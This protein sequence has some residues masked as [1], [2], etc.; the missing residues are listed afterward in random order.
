MTRA[1][2]R[3]LARLGA[4]DR[5][6]A[7]H[8]EIALIHRTFP[9]LRESAPPTNP[10]TEGVRAAVAGVGPAVEGAV[11]RRRPQISA[12]GRKAIG[13]AAKRRWAAWRAQQDEGKGAA[14]AETKAAGPA[15]RRP[16]VRDSHVKKSA[17]K[18]R[19]RKKK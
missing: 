6:R 7:L 19:A 15:R 11:T 12:A 17:K 1:E 9:D 3:R 18:G 14:S 13:D 16:N 4:E 2:L 10:Y 8:A 5:L